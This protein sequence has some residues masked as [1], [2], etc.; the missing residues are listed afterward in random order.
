MSNTAHPKQSLVHSVLTIN[1]SVIAVPGKV[2]NVRV[3]VYNPV[4]GDDETITALI[5]WD[6]LTPEEAGGVVNHYSVSIQ[7]E[8]TVEEITVS[9]NHLYIH[10]HGFESH[11]R[12]LIFSRKSDCLGCA[13]LLCLVCLF[14]LAC[15]FLPSHLSFKN[16][17]KMYMSFK[18]MYMCMHVLGNLCHIQ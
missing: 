11:L 18:N 13:V 14:D 6:A 10:V 12:Q 15:F 17:Y 3:Y 5:V 2:M 8:G 16:M 7:E 4:L 9:T 1:I